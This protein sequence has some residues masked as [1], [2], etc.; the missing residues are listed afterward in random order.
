MTPNAR[1]LWSRLRTDGSPAGGFIRLRFPQISSC[2]VYAAR[3][4]DSGLEALILEVDK[5]S[6][7]TQPQYPRT[8]G[9]EVSAE[10]LEPGRTG[11]TRLLLSLAEERYR[12]VF[13]ALTDDV[14][15]HLAATTDADEAVQ[16]V[17]QRLARWRLF[18]EQHDPEGLS[19][20][21]Q[22]G[23]F[24][25]L[26]ILQHLIGLGLSPDAAVRS[27]RGPT[28]SSKD[29]Q[30]AGGSLEVK[31][32]VAVTPSVFRVNNAQQLD[33]SGVELLI[34]ALVHL[35]E[36]ESRG[37]SLAELV[38]EVER[39]LPAA[40]LPSWDEALRTVGFLKIQSDRYQ[41]LR[42]L[43]RARH[44]F[45]VMSGFPR[46]IASDLSSGIVDVAYSVSIPSIEA[47]RC[48]ESLLTRLVPEHVSE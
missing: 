4:I 5:Q 30:L 40:T 36:T 33:D 15:S 44:F 46:L 19:T 9:F 42:Y 7:P 23:L 20:T 16:D 6:I 25:E 38:D 12:D 26:V 8:R 24:G 37:K 28:G 32:T 39:A 10:S 48:D 31:T 45:R 13:Q 17:L 11:T 18:L 27:W 1:S 3:R 35:E 2:P 41:D 29:F 43:V 14:V 21:E 22:R 47:Y 34:L